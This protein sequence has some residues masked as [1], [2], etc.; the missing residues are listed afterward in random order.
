MNHSESDAQEDDIL[1]EYDLTGKVGVRGKYSQS[2]KENGYTIKVNHADGTT[3]VRYV[4][5]EGTVVLDPDVREYFPDEEAVNN[6]LRTLIAL[7]QRKTA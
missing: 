5:P 1:P 7:V 3:S 2:L 4:P 6:A